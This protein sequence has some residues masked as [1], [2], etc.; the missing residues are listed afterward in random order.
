M[1]C[2]KCV[3]ACRRKGG[4]WGDDSECL[5]KCDNCGC[6]G[7]PPDQCSCSESCF[8]FR[9]EKDHQNTRHI[10]VHKETVYQCRS[11]DHTVEIH[12]AD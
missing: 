7:N 11:C 5:C 3:E 12:P 1:I 4:C 9:S 8:I 10:M 2:P 6:F